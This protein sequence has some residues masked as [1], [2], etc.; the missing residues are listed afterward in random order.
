ML[1]DNQ[2]LTRTPKKIFQRKVATLQCKI[3]WFTAYELTK[4]TSG[5][6]KVTSLQII[7]KSLLLLLIL[8]KIAVQTKHLTYKREI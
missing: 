8:I 3:R 6:R 7:Y 2:L 5:E 4:H 1:K